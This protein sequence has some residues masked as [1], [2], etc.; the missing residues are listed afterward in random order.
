MY[1]SV[2]HLSID[3]VNTKLHYQRLKYYLISLHRSI[4]F[5]QLSFLFLLLLGI[6]RV[7]CVLAVAAKKI[8]S[9]GT[10]CYQ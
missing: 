4:Y 5:K 3:H 6:G 9:L 10:G 8:Q 1:S 7:H 2:K